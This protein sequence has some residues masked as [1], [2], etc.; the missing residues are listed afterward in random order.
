MVLD[1]MGASLTMIKN[2]VVRV[3]LRGFVHVDGVPVCRYIKERDA[4]EFVDKDRRRSA[5]RGRR[6]VEIKL[7]ELVKLREN[8]KP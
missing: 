7:D 3:D 6:Q 8:R 1:G 5:V 4:L 2:P